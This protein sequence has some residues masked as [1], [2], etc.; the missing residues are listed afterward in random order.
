LLSQVVVRLSF[1]AGQNKNKTALGFEL[2][3]LMFNS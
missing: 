1:E 2:H 3:T